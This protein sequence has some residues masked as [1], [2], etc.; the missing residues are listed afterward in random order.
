MT[1]QPVR[2]P[3][4][5]SSIKGYP[6]FLQRL[7]IRILVITVVLAFWVLNAVSSPN[8]ISVAPESSPEFFE[9]L[10]SHTTITPPVDIEA[11]PFPTRTP[12]PQL[13]T[14]SP[15]RDTATPYIADVPPSFPSLH[16][17]AGGI[18]EGQI[19]LLNELSHLPRYEIEVEL[20][21][22]LQTL[23]GIA[24]VAIFNSSSDSWSSLVF[25]LPANLPRLWANMQIN[26][27]QVDGR[28]I[29]HLHS[30]E[31]TLLIIPLENPLEPGV[32]IQVDLKWQLQYAIFNNLDH[33][34]RLGK[35]QDMFNLPHFYPELAVFAP[36]KPGTN[37]EGWWIAENQGYADIRYHE[38]TLMRVTATLPDSLVVVGSGHLTDSVPLE[39]G[40]TKYQWVTGPV[41]GFV[42]QAS[43]SYLTSSLESDGVT[44]RTYYH[45]E[46]EEVALRTLAYA[47]TA[48][49]T[50][51]EHWGPYPFPHLY[52]VSS[53]LNDSGLEYS[54]LIQYG[55]QRYRNYPYDTAFL[56]IHEVAHQW[57][58]LQVHNDPVNFPS[59]DEGFA[60]LAYILYLEENSTEI[61]R[62]NMTSYWR[63]L[64][65]NYESSFEG[66]I[67]W[68]RAVP[69]RNHQHYYLANYRRPAVL[70]AD[71]W[72]AAGDTAFTEVLRN[73]ITEH[74][75]QIVGP[76]D[77]EIE[78]QKVASVEQ[79]ADLREAWHLPASAPP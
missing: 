1:N 4:G 61:G 51:E 39:D 24:S 63:S 31:S 17:Y 2:N 76:E 55:V 15:F 67:P 38:S 60:E 30:A 18:R 78:F 5:A 25:R 45:A 26:S 41:R 35:N 50:F 21:P 72:S 66:E 33:Y 23:E 37:P 47:K 3:N 52:I 36:G 79:L 10:A 75:F 64:L 62:E 16:V 70:L 54:N 13:P 77:W 40:R 6:S 9:A 32:W 8:S 14:P 71:I 19:T 12:I 69:Y 46:D 74:R 43:P 42:L 59:L 20:F 22:A 44:L 58:Y 7:L 11:Q 34:V 68:W 65:L 53:P 56:M 48:L 49:G 27:V 28:R 73:F 29:K 57:W